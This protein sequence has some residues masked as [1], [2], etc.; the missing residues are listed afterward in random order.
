VYKPEHPRVRLNH[1]QRFGLRVKELRSEREITQEELAERVGVF[2]TYMSRIETGA[3][4]P[5][6]TTVHALADSLD[7]DV[8]VLFES[9]RASAQTRARV[10]QPVSRGRVRK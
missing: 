3:A 7:V 5:T 10:R 9:P 4:N 8:A 6:L 2:R 1:C